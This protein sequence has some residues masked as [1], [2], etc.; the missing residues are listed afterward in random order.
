MY[1][2]HLTSEDGKMDAWACG[3]CNSMFA[4]LL[5][6]GVAREHCGWPVCECGKPVQEHR[7]ACGAC[8]AQHEADKELRVYGEAEKIRWQDYDGDMVY[9]PEM[10]EY[11]PDV[12]TMLDAEDDPPDDPPR[13]AWA[14][15][16][17]KLKFDASD[18]VNAQLEADSHH[19]DSAA[20]VD[21]D[22]IVELQKLL[23]AWCEKQ[24]VE[25][26]FPDYSRVVT[27]DDIV[28]ER[29]ADQYDEDPVSEGK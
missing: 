16:S 8:I 9:S 27:C 10:H 28:D 14:C 29:L 2:V 22:D 1:L 4:G 3:Y 19:E 26:Y 13:W 11:Y 21:D 6:E 17:L 5:A 12:D 20:A 24:T 15:T 25:T 23:D 7:T 18:I